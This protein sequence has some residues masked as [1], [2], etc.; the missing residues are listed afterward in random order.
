M[1][2]T[3]RTTV[4]VATIAL[5]LSAA[6]CT[7]TT[8]PEPS[9]TPTASASQAPSTSPSPT[10]SAAPYEDP[11]EPAGSLARADF[12]VVDGIPTT[13]TTAL[14]GMVSGQAFVIEG[15][16]VGGESMG[17][18]L[19]RAE[20]SDPEERLLV[21]GTLDCDVAADQ[22]LAYAFPYDG[23]VQLT[24]APDEDVTQA[25]AIVRAT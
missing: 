19:D 23:P 11:G 2:W 18:R 21:E 15:Q 4:A 1:D 22:D 8:T 5:T 10:P 12:A 24:I 13:S 17:F 3:H 14:G 6:A 7:S 16:C 25:W 20:G 9:P